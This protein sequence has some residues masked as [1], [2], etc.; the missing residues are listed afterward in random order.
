MKKANEFPEGWDDSRVREL[1]DHYENQTDAEA[2]AEHEA[3]LAQPNSRRI[4]GVL[5]SRPK[6]PNR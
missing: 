3:A 4:F 6:D 2:M 5:K 1:I